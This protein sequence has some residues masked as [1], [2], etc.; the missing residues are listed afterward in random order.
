MN[1]IT[2]RDVVRAAMTTAVVLGTSAAVAPIVLAD[3]APGSGTRPD[4]GADPVPPAKT[5][6]EVYRGRRIQ[7]GPTPVRYAS[8]RSGAPATG[9][10]IEVSIDGRPLHVMRRADGTYLSLVNHYQSFATPLEV[11]RA[12]VD[13]IGTAQLS[14]AR[15]HQHT[16]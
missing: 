8:S 13:E 7:G 15:L 1:T 9:P 10:G 3:P 11:A 16:A 6:D 4:G 12:A 5:F 2:R 14:T